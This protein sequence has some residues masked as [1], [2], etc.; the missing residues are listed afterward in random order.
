MYYHSEPHLLELTIKQELMKWQRIQQTLLIA[1]VLCYKSLSL[2]TL[3]WS[4]VKLLR[5]A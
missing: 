5:D 2:N 4:C 1:T 3:E